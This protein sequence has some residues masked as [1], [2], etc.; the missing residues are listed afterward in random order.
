VGSEV[1]TIQQ[2]L[3]AGVLELALEVSFQKSTYIL[4]VGYSI[5]NARKRYGLNDSPEQAM[6]LDFVLYT[7]S[8]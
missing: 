2:D 6:L 8:C 4:R 7:M 5:E 3:W 1:G